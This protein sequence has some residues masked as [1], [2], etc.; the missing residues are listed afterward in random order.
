VIPAHY[1]DLLVRRG[2]ARELPKK[3]KAAAKPKPAEVKPEPVASA[4]SV[5]PPTKKEIKAKLRALGVDV[6][7]AANKETLIALYD[8]ARKKTDA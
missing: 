3:R 1:A 5:V 4:V 6:P 8:E 7:F 2:L